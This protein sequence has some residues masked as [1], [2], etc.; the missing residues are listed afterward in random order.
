MRGRGS[1]AGR[2]TAQTPVGGGGGSGGAGGG[3]RRRRRRRRQPPPAQP[4]RRRI[5]TPP[6]VDPNT[7]PTTPPTSDVAAFEAT[8]YPLLRSTANFCVGCHGATQI[9]TFAVADVMTAYNVITTQQKVN[10]ANPELSRVY[11]RPAVDRHN[12]GANA[13]CDAIA[14]SFLAG[15]SRVGAAA[16]HDAAADAA[17]AHEL[18]DELRGGRRPASTRAD[19]NL[20]AKFDFDEGTG[21]TTV[22]SSGVGAPITLQITRHGVGRTAACATCPA[23]R[24]RTRPTAASCST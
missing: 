3:G 1:R 10:L 11:L 8:L 7:P 18:E 12:C 20:I 15:D 23:K 14:A 2:S 5:T 13:S 24:K 9:P 4:R 22:D 6:P 19:G 17:V 16:A 21:T